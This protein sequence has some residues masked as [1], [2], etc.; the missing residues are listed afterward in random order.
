MTGCHNRYCSYTYAFFF[1]LL[2]LA[3]CRTAEAG[4]WPRIVESGVLRVG[5]D[6]T[7]PP[8]ETADDGELRGLDVDLARALA[9]DLGLQP[10]F[11]YFGYDGLYDALVT[12]QVD[13]L[14]SALVVQ[15]ERTR[16]FAYSDSYFNAGEVL[17][18]RRDT[19]S[20]AGMADMSGRTLAV[21]L[22]ALGHVEAIQWAR[23]L[24]NLDILP[25]NTPDDALAAVSQGEVDAVLIDGVSGRL[26]LLNQPNLRI[27]DAA[28]TLE[29]YALVVR[30]EDDLLLQKLNESLGRL[31]RNGRVEEI[32]QQWLGES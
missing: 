4:A 2:L 21:E 7:Y 8:F 11:V 27:V 15:I 22:G 25:Y 16:D 19:E 30:K 12:H 18:S 14:I 9:A 26:Y 20:I 10:E 6:P 13:M 31:K 24:P 29:P 17:I 23:R 28:V 3:A 5:L 1:L 32:I